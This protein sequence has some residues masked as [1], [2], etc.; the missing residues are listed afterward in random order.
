MA[1]MARQLG[2]LYWGSSGFGTEPHRP[3]G[4]TQAL[5]RHAL[6][7]KGKQM[8]AFFTRLTLRS[9]TRQFHHKYLSR[10]DNHISWPL[11]QL[12]KSKMKAG[13]K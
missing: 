5:R 2:E 3:E 6:R 7:S 12:G 13:R 9:V 1:R 4:D 11:L 8:I 10:I